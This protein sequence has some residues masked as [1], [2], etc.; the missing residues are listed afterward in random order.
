M[1]GLRNIN[2]RLELFVDDWL[3][4]EMNGVSLQMHNPI[5]QEVVLEFNR[6]W[7]GSIS[8]DPVVM[9][10]EDRYRLW[11]RGCGSE[12]TWEAQCTAYAESADGV[13]WER[14]TLGIF[15]FNGSRDNNIVLQG[16]EAKA[17]CVFK[18]P[19]PNTSDSE[20]YKAIGVGS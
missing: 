1:E 12:S 13:H 7:E 20:R 4:E 10:E 17:L 6:P 2:S 11:Y 16:T 8:Y 3:I 19:N 9:K 18:D 14:P 15:E 5:P